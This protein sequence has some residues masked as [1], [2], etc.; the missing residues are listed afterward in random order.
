MKYEWRKQE[1]DIYGIKG[2]ACVIDVAPQKFISISGCGN[3]NNREFS[4]KVSALYTLSYQ[5]KKDFKSFALKAKQEV[6]DYTVYPLE[7]VWSKLRETEKLVKEEL[8]YK[9]MIRQ[10]DFI[11]W[12]MVEEALKAVKRK[13]P[14][15]Y[16]SDIFSETIQD[17]KC[18]QILHTGSFDDEP[19]TFERL[20]WF[21]KENNL[22]RIG[23]A[24]RE[25]YLNNANRVSEEKLKTILRYKVSSII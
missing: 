7:G 13:K 11:T 20:E 22:G 17:G 15:Q 8:Q 16:L 24:H 12:E 25:I 4:E 21:C 14:N 9:I 23:S 1:K 19:V 3:P 6:N 2:E 18:V 5:I 10:P